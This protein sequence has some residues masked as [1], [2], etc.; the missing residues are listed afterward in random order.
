MFWWIALGVI[1]V[2]LGATYLFGRRHPGSVSDDLAANSR[3]K[4]EG[5]GGLYQG[6]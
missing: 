3:R 1:L 4:D 2:I 5:R 6:P